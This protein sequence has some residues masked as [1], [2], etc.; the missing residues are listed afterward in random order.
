MSSIMHCSFF[1][2]SRLTKVSNTVSLK[3]SLI[4][5]SDAQRF[6]DKGSLKQ[7][8]ISL[9]SLID[10]KH[11]LKTHPMHLKSFALIRQKTFS[12]N[13]QADTQCFDH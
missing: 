10:R 3:L 11:H 12:L 2:P 4:I 6:R 9:V 7:F 5:L 1:F 8:S 13:T